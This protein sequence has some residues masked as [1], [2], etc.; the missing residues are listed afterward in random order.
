MLPTPGIA[1]GKSSLMAFPVFSHARRE[2]EQRDGLTQVFNWGFI[3]PHS[4]VF[5]LIVAVAE[6]LFLS[7]IIPLPEQISLLE[8][9]PAMCFQHGCLN[10][11][12]NNCVLKLYIGYLSWPYAT[13][14]GGTFHI[15]FFCTI[16][17]HI[18]CILVPNSHMGN[19]DINFI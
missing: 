2:W 19:Y 4:S 13:S 15:T 7:I 8:L 17:K 5:S 16:V 18:S 11:G 14:I 9:P 3:A 10:E 6:G 1:L 12:L